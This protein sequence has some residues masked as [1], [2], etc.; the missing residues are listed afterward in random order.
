MKND[1]L[2]KLS[3]DSFD[4]DEF[5]LN[6]KNN[7]SIIIDGIIDFKEE[8][9]LIEEVEVMEE[10]TPILPKREVSHEVEDN[11][12]NKKQKKEKRETRQKKRSK[13]FKIPSDKKGKIIYLIQAI[14][15]ILSIVFI[16]GCCIFYG[17]R[18]IK[19]YRIYNPKTEAGEVIELIGSSITNSTPY[20]TEGEGLYRIGG[21]SIFKGQNVNNYLYFAN[22]MWRIV[23]INPDGSLE[24]T[25]DKYINA[26]S[27]D[28]KTVTFD[29]S[30]LNK[31]LNEI[32]LNTLNKEYLSQT[33]Y[34]LD[35]VEDIASITCKN[36]VSTDYVRIL[37]VSEFLNSKVEAQTYLSSEDGYWIYNTSSEGAWHTSGV[38]LSLASYTEGYLVKPVIRIKNSV[39]L[40]GGKGS[41]EDPYYI[42]KD[43][44][45]LEVGNYIKLGDDVWVVYE[46]KD[47]TINLA[48]NKTISATHRFSNSTNKYDVNDKNSLAA[49]LNTTYLQNLTYKDMLNDNEWYIGSY[50][51][52]YENIY[53]TKVTAKVGIYNVADLKI[54]NSNEMFYL[55]TPSETNYA[56]LYNMGLSKSKITL[57]RNIKPTININKFGVESGKG[58]INDPYILG[59]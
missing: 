9:N 14:F 22:Q 28:D 35:E 56:Y 52:N 26:L 38:S 17:S 39:Q 53:K 47:N 36:I 37:G 44:K 33:A 40:L 25:T 30:N 55:M 2:E 7:D 29:K 32:F 21:A 34:C 10:V 54:N 59:E 48:L 18:L 23:T 6:D 27:F 57:S 19:Y 1:D 13:G 5:M 51:Y 8:E 20:V 16:L 3:L 4:E 45:N 49:Y 42:E 46:V 11:R 43:D 58:T 24:I 15:C 31:Y 50:D 12:N 41:L